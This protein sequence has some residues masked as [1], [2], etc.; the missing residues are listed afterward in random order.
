MVPWQTPQR[1]HLPCQHMEESIPRTGVDVGKTTTKREDH[2][3]TRLGVELPLPPQILHSWDHVHHPRSAII[4]QENHF[5]RTMVES[6][7]ENC[8]WTA[9]VA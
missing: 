6:N 2:S 4:H 7:A 3:G 9:M 1:S 8:D 5:V